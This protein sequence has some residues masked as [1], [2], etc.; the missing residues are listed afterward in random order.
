MEASRETKLL[1]LQIASEHWRNTFACATE[2][3][4]DHED[5]VW[6]RYEDLAQAPEEEL[7]RVVEAIDVEYDPD[8]IPR[9]SHQLPFGSSEPH[10][11][12]PI[13]ADTNGKHLQHLDAG[14]AS[15]IRETVGDVAER[16]GY[17]TPTDS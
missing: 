16:F 8:M 2:D 12:F 15:V 6:L 17:C 3:L 1:K 4:E 5:T 7:R 9:E 10:K 14:M 11:W 13:R